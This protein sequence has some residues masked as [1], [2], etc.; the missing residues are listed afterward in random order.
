MYTFV[1]CG[2]ICRTAEI[3]RIQL[4]AEFTMY[5][6]QSADL[7]DIFTCH[8][9]DMSQTW[10]IH[11]HVTHINSMWTRIKSM[12]THIKSMW[13]RHKHKMYVDMSYKALSHPRGM[14]IHVYVCHTSHWWRMVFSQILVR[15]FMCHQMCPTHLWHVSQRHMWHVSQRHIQNPTHLMT[16]KH[17]RCNA[18]DMFR[19]DIFWIFLCGTCHT[20]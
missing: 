6:L 10:K 7:W 12:W 8:Q 5:N 13:T 20:H 4:V 16:H 3:L 18:C 19:R 14:S 1:P 17:S 2:W 11:R 15:M 9:W